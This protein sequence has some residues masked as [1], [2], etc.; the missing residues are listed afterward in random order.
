[1]PSFFEGLKRIAQGKPVYQY[2]GSTPQSSTNAQGSETNE[3]RRTPKVYIE[4]TETDIDG[5]KM[6]TYADIKNESEETVLLDKIRLLGTTREIDTTL[7]AQ[8]RKEILIYDGKAPD[9]NRDHDAELQYKDMNDNYYKA[10][11]DVRFEPH[12]DLYAI[13]K[14]PYENTSRM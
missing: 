2:T 10:R 4:R 7:K 6:R 12:G 14:M 1:M 11:H 5:D 13:D 8:D 9:N 3:V